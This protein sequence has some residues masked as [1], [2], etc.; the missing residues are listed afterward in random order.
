M[1][2]VRNNATPLVVPDYVVLSW[3]RSA[4]D[5]YYQNSIGAS[6]GIHH[7]FNWE[8]SRIV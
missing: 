7:W 3:S 4:T 5:C 2:L 8:Y 6:W 1:P